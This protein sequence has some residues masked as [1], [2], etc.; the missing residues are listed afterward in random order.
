MLDI[1][2]I[3]I[4]K[5]FET[6]SYEHIRI[7]M[8]KG[9]TFAD[10]KRREEFSS[11]TVGLDKGYVH[12]DFVSSDSAPVCGMR[13]LLAIARSAREYLYDNPHVTI[14][15]FRHVRGDISIRP[16]SVKGG[17]HAPVDFR[18]LFD[19]DVQ[20]IYRLCKDNSERTYLFN[21]LLCDT[22]NYCMRSV[23]HTEEGLFGPS[24]GGIY[25]NAGLLSHS[26][27]AMNALDI[28]KHI[29]LLI[30]TKRQRAHMPRLSSPDRATVQCE[31]SLSGSA[32]RN[33]IHS[34]DYLK[35]SVLKHA[36][37]T[38]PLTGSEY[39]MARFVLTLPFDES[40]NSLTAVCAAELRDFAQ[41]FEYYL[42]AKSHVDFLTADEILSLAAK[43]DSSVSETAHARS[44]NWRLSSRLPCPPYYDSRGKAYWE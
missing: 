39:D 34:V 37:E 12:Y 23:L 30:K 16:V 31:G 11:C 3:I 6:G 2:G 36:T 38:L 8:Y 1:A 13:Q 33:A 4:F 40:I 41:S 17:V 32:H 28:P 9:R 19:S 18:V 21:S 42:K 43:S 44:V 27:A 7:T 15:E 10:I 24:G 35:C 20:D 29:R 26:K 25:V 14:A 22:L 5:N